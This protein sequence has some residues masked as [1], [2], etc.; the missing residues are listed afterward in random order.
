MAKNRT[1]DEYQNSLELLKNI[2]SL[3]NDRAKNQLII[4]ERQKIINELLAEGVSKDSERGKLLTKLIADQQQEI[5]NEKSLNTQLENQIKSRQRNVSLVKDLVGLIKQEWQYLQ[6]SDKTIKGTILSLGMSGAKADLMRKSFVDSAKFVAR[7]GGSLADVQSIQ[8]GYADETGRARAMTASMVED[9]TLIG[10]GTGL[11]IEQATKLGAQ[12]EFMGLDAK[13]SMDYV[14]GIVDTSERMGINTTKVLK[15]VS[16]N[17][18]KLNTYSFTAGVKGMAKMAEDAEKFQVDMKDAL[19]AADA[20]KGLEKAIDLAANLQIMGG[21]FAKTDPFEWMYLARNEPEKLTQKISEMT[22]G[23]VTFKKNSEG[24]FEKFI[25]PADRQ[26][27]E[28]VAKSLG[29]SN[30]EMVKIT[31]RRADLDKMNQQ[32]AGTGL[33]GREK[34]LVQG[35]AI[36]NAKSGKFQVEMAGTMHDISSLTAEQAKSFV[37]EQASLKSRAEQALTFD[38]TFKATI[39]ILKA[40]LLPLLTTINKVMSVTIKPLADL[41]TKGWG[42]AV[43]A[44]G[45]LLTAATA[46][47]IITNSL[48]KF[49]DKYI[50]GTAKK[51]ATS[52]LG[53]IGG[54]A[55]GRAETTI[56]EKAGKGL[57]GLA[58]QRKGIGAGAAAAG[59]GKMFAGAGA[60]I[61]AAALGVGAG[62][63]AAAAGISLLATA[64][65]KLTPEQAKTLNSIVKSIALVV[66]IGAAAAA[67]IMIFGGASTAAA[68]G[69]LAFGGAVALVGAGVGIAAAGIGVMALGLSKLAVSAKGSGKDLME[70]GVGVAA[71]AAGMA[72]FTVGGLGLI[73]FSLTLNRI[74]KNAD[75]IAK[76]GDAFRQINTVM[77]GSKEDFVAIENAVNSISSMNTNGGS[78]LAQLTTLLKTPLKVEFA[79][80]EMNIAS[81]ITLDIDGQRFMNKIF[82]NKIAVTHQEE[83]RTQ[84]V[85]Q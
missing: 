13:R 18:K 79:N 85:N 74:A 49:A 41:A 52:T 63:G 54:S 70:M 44:G 23:L 61:G 67:A 30:E 46:W 11:G 53:N 1:V 62:I 17:F 45:I 73:A 64:M 65:A 48:G 56:A 3:D 7:L 9:I 26:R 77:H 39:E 78:A 31:Q 20:A 6:E 81:N 83:L 21:E 80:K 51:A 5:T 75:A 76:V 33:S 60:G 12:F 24:V 40:S 69:L 28:S 72:L 55:A 66:G 34:E 25:S 35:A 29:I 43:A 42:G 36:F 32:L 19:S 2:N 84:S 59:K 50:T 27:L 14:Q 58:E 22:R 71:M 37:K 16:D 4:S 68:P 10:K 57:S 82:K 38:Q 47:K 15:N 8:Q